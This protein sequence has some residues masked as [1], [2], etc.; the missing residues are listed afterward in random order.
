[1]TDD[2]KRELKEGYV[3]LREH[4]E[5]LIRE[6]QS[7]MELRFKAQHEALVLKADELERRLEALNELRKS[8]ERDRDEFIKKETYNIKTSWYDEWCRGV[9]KRLTAS[10]TRAVTWT[11]AIAL[12]FVIVQ[13]ALRFWK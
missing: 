11:A 10:E 6:R 3:N 12:F 2:D 8:V 7:Q 13:V 5:M 4:L 9:D 1:M